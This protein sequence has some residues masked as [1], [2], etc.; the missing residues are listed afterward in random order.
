MGELITLP[1]A[2]E[3]LGVH[4][5]TVYRYVRTGRLS[6]TKVGAEY[7]VKPADLAALRSAPAKT[8]GRRRVDYA[9]RLEERLLAGDE[10]GAWSIV[11]DALTAGV[12]PV[13]I[14]LQVLSPALRSIGDRWERG[15]VSIALEHRASVVAHRLISRLGPRFSR[16]GRKRGT[17]VIGAA[18]RD[19]HGLPSALLGD[20]LRS[21]GFIV[22]DLGADVPVE[23]WA[24]SVAAAER[25]VAVAVGATTGGNDRQV[26]AAV[27]AVRGACAAPVVLGGYAITDAAHARS[28][29]AD[30]HGASGMAAVEAIDALVATP[31]R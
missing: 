17:V 21:R 5:M 18:P 28:L 20:L 26:R 3:S 1:E 7:R 16:R 13:D 19:L 27:R 9:M 2:A 15:E 30:L 12:E 29:G 25:L 4:Y 8:R 24:E 23:S 31:V 11:E 10:A 6:A 22:T 14:H